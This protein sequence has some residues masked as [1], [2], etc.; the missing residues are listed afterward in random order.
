MIYQRVEIQTLVVAARDLDEIPALDA[1]LR[2]RRGQHVGIRN[3][4][5]KRHLGQAVNTVDL[6]AH[7]FLRFALYAEHIAVDDLGQSVKFRAKDGTAPGKRVR[8][9]H[10]DKIVIFAQ[11]FKTQAAGAGLLVK[12]IAVFR[13]EADYADLC[14]A[15]CERLKRC[16]RVAFADDRIDRL[17]LR[18]SG[19]ILCRQIQHGRRARDAHAQPVRHGPLGAERFNGLRLAQNGLCVLQ[20]DRAACRGTDAARGTLKNAEA[21]HLLHIMQNTAEVRLPDE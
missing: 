12:I 16:A 10:G 14:L 1:V 13:T 15:A 8:L 17:C 4:F 9:V 5:E 7:R 20:E 21:K 11:K 2:D 6:P 19:Q 18:Q 3:G